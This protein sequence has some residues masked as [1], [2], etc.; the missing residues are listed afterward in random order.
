MQKAR[1]EVRRACIM[2]WDSVPIQLYGPG[3]GSLDGWSTGKV[4]G[5]PPY[6]HFRLSTTLYITSREAELL[7]LKGI[8]ISTNSGRRNS[9]WR[10]E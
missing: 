7:S 9:T 3:S 6:V 2:V 1:L 4:R 10:E 5:I 8:S